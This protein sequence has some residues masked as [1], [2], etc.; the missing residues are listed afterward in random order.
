MIGVLYPSTDPCLDL[1]VPVNVR[2]DQSR[3]E[4]EGVWSY[5]GTV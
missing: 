2:L 1:L 5:D 4:K 3:R